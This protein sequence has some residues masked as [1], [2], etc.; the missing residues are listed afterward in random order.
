M[1]FKDNMKKKSEGIDLEAMARQVQEAAAKA[2]KQAREKAG[3]FT[4]QNRERIDGYVEQAT[5]MF[6]EKTHAK[7]A[8]TVAKLKRQLHKGVDKIAEGSAAG[9]AA[10]SPPASPFPV[11]PEAPVVADPTPGDESGFNAAA[12]D[13]P[14][15]PHE[16]LHDTALEEAAHPNEAPA[17]VPTLSEPPGPEDAAPNPDRDAAR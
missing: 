5:S 7:Y 16:A 10:P 2:A 6:D 15:P 12:G 14:V 9:A 17:E 3:D 4:T 8:D 1:S 11:D 13:L